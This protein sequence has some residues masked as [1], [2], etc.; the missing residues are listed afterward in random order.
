MNDRKRIRQSRLHGVVSGSPA[1]AV[2]DDQQHSVSGTG[3]FARALHTNLF[4]G[5]VRVA[6]T[7]GVD[8]RN[9]NTAHNDLFAQAVTG[10]PCNVGHNGGIGSRQ[11]VQQTGLARVGPASQ[12]QGQAFGQRPAAAGFA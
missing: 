3:L 8:H 12:H 6:Y 7:G 11:A 4:H 1:L 9:G 5:I 2:V 10:G